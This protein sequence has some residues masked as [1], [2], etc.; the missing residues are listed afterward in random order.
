MTKPNPKSLQLLDE[1]ESNID[2][3]IGQIIRYIRICRRKNVN[4]KEM[5]LFYLKKIKEIK[6]KHADEIE[7]FKINE[8]K[9]LACYNDICYKNKRLLAV[10][11]NKDAEIRDINKNW[12]S[13]EN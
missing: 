12:G 3:I 5:E 11:S 4:S 6:K 7:H 1:I 13:K 2:R 10:L 9:I 8:E